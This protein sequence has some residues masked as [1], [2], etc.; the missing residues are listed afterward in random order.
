MI[1]RLDDTHDDG[2][3]CLY[4]AAESIQPFKEADEGVTLI[5]N[6]ADIPP[7]AKPGDMFMLIRQPIP[8]WPLLSGST[9]LERL[10][11]WGTV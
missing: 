3:A 10:K 7:E 6:L 8:A 5:V 11:N 9:V 4:I 1:I 2:T